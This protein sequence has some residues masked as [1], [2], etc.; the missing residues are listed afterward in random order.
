VKTAGRGAKRVAVPPD[1]SLP[2]TAPASD[3]GVLATMPSAART[4]TATPET[5]ATSRMKASQPEAKAKS[6][7][8][9][10]QEKRVGNAEVI[11]AVNDLSEFVE[12]MRQLQS[13]GGRSD[14]KTRGMFSLLDG[15]MAVLKRVSHRAAPA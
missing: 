15:Q 9:P 2:G 8:A 12:D 6:R 3:F 11:D 13:A 1:T 5:T 10:V 7:V 14:I 4:R